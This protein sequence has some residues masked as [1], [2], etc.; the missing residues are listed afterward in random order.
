M[1]E[2]KSMPVRVAQ[3]LAL[4]I[5]VAG[6]FSVQ[7]RL[8]YLY[9]DRP[10]S[11]PGAF[12]MALARWY[13][14]ALLTPLL[15][16]LARRFPFDTGR[17]LLAVAVHLPATFFIAIAA[18]TLEKLA[19]GFTGITPPRTSS[20]NDLNALLLTAWLISGICHAIVHARASNL[21]RQRAAQLES[22]LTRARLDLLRSQLQPHFL[23]NTLNS[24]VTL[25]RHDPDAAETMLTR[26]ADLLRLSL[27]LRD[28]QQVTLKEELELAQAYLAIQQVRF[29]D[30]PKFV[31]LVDP[32]LYDSLVPTMIVQPLIE[33]AVSHGLASTTAGGTVRLIAEREGD[34]LKI[35]IADDGRGWSDDAKEGIGLTHIRERIGELYGDAASLTVRSAD[36]GVEVAICFPADSSPI[37]REP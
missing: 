22:R 31:Q 29:G 6:F 11:W 15:Y 13:A 30:R 7:V 33:N 3:Y 20:I 34:R 28:C 8:D 1:L 9:L 10:I 27:D 19:V 2:S 23:F 26:L 25:I 17:R 35:V 36:P 32:S 24:V 21:R 14:W 37:E 12:A 4:W 5:L 16:L 18:A